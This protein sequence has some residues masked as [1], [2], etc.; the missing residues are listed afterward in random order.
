MVDFTVGHALLLQRIGSPFASMSLPAAATVGLGSLAGAIVICSR[1]W[2]RAQRIL[3]SRRAGLVIAWRALRLIRPV[4]RG[5]AA[6]QL[7]LYLCHAWEG[8][9][10]FTDAA[11]TT[12]DPAEALANIISI[13][14]SELGLSHTETLDTPLRQ[15]IWDICQFLHRKGSIQLITAA[16][17]DAFAAADRMAAE[18][19]A[20]Q[21]VAVP[22]SPCPSNTP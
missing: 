2:R 10:I 14:K 6:G 8:P 18:L 13:A 16:D 12:S 20:A 22:D 17:D 4:P 15:A 5:R 9:K 11:G 21:S 1:S 3:D 19:R 7:A